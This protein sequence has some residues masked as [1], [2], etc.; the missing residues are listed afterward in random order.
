MRPLLLAS[1]LVVMP[2]AARAA[3]APA[4]VAVKVTD[5]QIDFLAGNDLVASYHK[6]PEVA[7]PY[8]WPLLGPGGVHLT[9]DWPMTPKKEGGSSD[10]IHQKSAWFCHGDVIPEGLTLKDK[11]RGVEGVDFWAEPKG[12]GKMACV[13][14]SEPKTDGGHGQITTWNEWA[15]STGD[16]VLDEKRTIHLYNLGDS[17]LFVFEI[18]LAATNVPV[19]F[20][21]TKEGSFGVRINDDL[22]ETPAKGKKGVGKLENA[23]GKVGEKNIG[24]RRSAWCDYSGPLQGQV[25]G[26]AIFDDPANPPAC[27]HSRGYGLMAANP[28]GRAKSGFPDMKG[29]HDLLKLAKG[30]H[31]KLRYGLLLHPG[32]AKEGRVAEHY[33]RFL[34]EKK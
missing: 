7:K 22:R 31:L 9:R 10:H 5:S 26:L 6:G 14:V 27:W 15:T 33:Q 30:E 4:P 13:R 24:G 3:D 23:E 25:V 2:V 17:R 18:D 29:N 20:G 11:V 21:D 32:D 12:H 16:K 1:L 19:V 8:L 34:K 28:F